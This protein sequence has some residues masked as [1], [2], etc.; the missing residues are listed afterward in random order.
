[1]KKKAAVIML[2]AVLTAGTVFSSA[3]TASA[4]QTITVSE[5]EYNLTVEDYPSFTSEWDSVYSK[6]N[7]TSSTSKYAL[8]LFDDW[9]STESMME[10]FD[11][12]G[13]KVDMDNIIAMDVILYQLD[14]DDEYY[15]VESSIDVTVICPIPDQFY[16]SADKVQLYQLTAAGKLSKASFT[17]VSV[18]GVT[19]AKF[20]VRENSNYAFV[21]TDSYVVPEKEQAATPTPVPTK[22][23][24]ATKAPTAAPTKAPAHVEATPAPRPQ[25]SGSQS[26][27]QSVQ[28]GTAAQNNSATQN[29]SSASGSTASGSRPVDHTPQT[30]DTAPVGLWTG[31]VVISGAAMIAAIWWLKKK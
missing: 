13:N 25:S 11:K 15:P 3:M 12:S 16:D 17:Q 29:Q 18:N 24:Q 5:S 19:C 23:P 28:N 20:T 7:N 31:G 9:T 1:M 4:A 14:S 26:S 21:L 6:M 22:Q 27:T 2:S 8:S 30:G 10:A